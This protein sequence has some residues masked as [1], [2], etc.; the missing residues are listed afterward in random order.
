MKRL[1]TLML[2]YLVSR[3]RILLIDDVE[4]HMNPSMLSLMASWLC[5]L[6]ERDKVTLVIT[7]HSLEAAKLLADMMSELDS[8]IVLVDLRNGRLVCRSLSLDEVEKLEGLGIDVRL[9]SGV[10]L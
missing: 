6:V 3:P 5:D 9:A 7:T 1:A 4:A 8:H 2:L 10:L